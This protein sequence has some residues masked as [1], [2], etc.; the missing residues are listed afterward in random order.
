M[1]L[2]EFTLHLST[3]VLLEILT[4]L[5]RQGMPI[6]NAVAVAVADQATMEGIWDDSDNRVLQSQIDVTAVKTGDGLD[7]V[8]MLMLEAAPFM[9]PA[10]VTS[11][12]SRQLSPE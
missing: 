12:M 5:H 10:T 9:T 8:P 11:K 6:G 7:F 4:H 1:P 2:P 3:S